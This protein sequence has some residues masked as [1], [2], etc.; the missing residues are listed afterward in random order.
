[1]A[2]VNCLGTRERENR[3]LTRPWRLVVAASLQR[4]TLKWNLTFVSTCLVATL[5]VRS[6]LID[7]EAIVS[8]DSG[9]AV[10]DLLRSWP[11]NLSAVLCAHKPDDKQALELLRE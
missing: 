8:N 4:W 1:M 6:C 7:G 2:R 9:L 10:L 11:T 3:T 5:P